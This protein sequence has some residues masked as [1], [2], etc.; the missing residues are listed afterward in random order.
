MPQAVEVVARLISDGKAKDI[1]VIAGADFAYIFDSHRFFDIRSP[2]TGIYSNLKKYH[3]P[4]PEAIFDIEYF[5]MK[6][7]AFYALAR[8]L[9]PN[10]KYRPNIA[11]Y[12]FRLL[13]QKR[14]LRRVYT[15]NID[16]LERVAGIPPS[17]LVEAHGT[18]ATAQ[19]LK[20]E[21]SIPARFVKAAIDKGRIARCYRCKGL[22]KP[23]IVFYNEDLPPRFWRFRQDM[24][25][26][27]LVLV[28]GTTLEVQPFSKLIASAPINTPRVLFNKQVV[29]P[30]KYRR[31]TK[32]YVALGDISKLIRELCSLLD[33]IDELDI[34]MKDA[35]LRRIDYIGL[36]PPN[37]TDF[38]QLREESNRPNERNSARGNFAIT[39]KVSRRISKAC[40]DEQMELRASVF[41]D[42]RAEAG[43]NDRPRHVSAGIAHRQNA[44]HLNSN[45]RRGISVPPIHVKY[46]EKEQ[47]ESN[48]KREIYEKLARET[49]LLAKQLSEVKINKKEGGK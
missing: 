35:E 21:R 37:M 2:K 48:T 29:G 10:G 27:D 6:P 18:F 3:L 49:V 12:F 15:Q 38:L 17:K 36:T 45:R 39:P 28:M 13:S 14:L 32:D 31:R 33:W 8:E 16:G 30:F 9:Y 24:P 11:H 20:C 46:E 22:V 43:S 23:D 5:K 7:G 25:K 42:R 1:I 26:C 40:L 44:E 34:L 47:F 4:Y 19:C 41:A